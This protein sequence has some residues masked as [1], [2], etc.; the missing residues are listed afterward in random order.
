MNRVIVIFGLLL[1]LLG[2]VLALVLMRPPVD[3]QAVPGDVVTDAGA[4]ANQSLA[5][6]LDE[7]PPQFQA[8]W[9]PDRLSCTT[10]GESARVEISANGMKFYESFG[11]LRQVTPLN[12]GREYAIALSVTGEGTTWTRTIHLRRVGHELA[13]RDADAAQERLFIRC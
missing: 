4:L 2:G 8:S 13:F 7:I 9:A 3:S 5:T 1:V 12:S 6:E 11:Q 10:R